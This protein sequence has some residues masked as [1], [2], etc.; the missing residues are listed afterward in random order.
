MN[1]SDVQRKILHAVVANASASEMEI[2]RTLEIRHHIVRRTIDMF[3]EKQVFI[4][5]S[6][7]VN[8]YALGLNHEAMHISLPLTSQK[9]YTKFRNLL[10]SC[11]EAVAVIEHGGAC[12]VEL[13]TYTRSPA[14]LQAFLDSLAKTFPHPFRIHSSLTILEQEYYG[15]PDPDVSPKMRTIMGYAPL[16][17]GAT[18]ARIDERDHTILS[19]LC[20]AKYL[21]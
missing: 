15:V 11:E 20:N 21:N 5:R 4:Q 13:R 19:A 7:F 18:P 12:Q 9:H 17:S 3:L 8:P 14:H 1:L 10:A 16:A 6:A 2:A